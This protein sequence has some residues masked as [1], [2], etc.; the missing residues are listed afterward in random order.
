MSLSK[1]QD[2]SFLAKI[3]QWKKDT[4]F[5]CFIVRNSWNTL[6]PIYPA[7][8]VDPFPVLTDAS[9]HAH[10][11]DHSPDTWESLSVLTDYQ[12]T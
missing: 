6:Q 1:L 11:G 3:E 8:A 2:S 5:E 4:Y 9:R 7:N 12:N 10:K